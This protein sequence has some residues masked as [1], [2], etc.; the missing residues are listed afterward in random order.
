LRIKALVVLATAMLLFGIGYLFY[1]NMLVALVCSGFSYYAIPAYRTYMRERRDRM[2]SEQFRYVLY[3]LSSLL[4]AGRSVE[5][6]FRL[7]ENDLLTL[8]STSSLVVIPELVRVNGKVSNGETIEKALYE[9]GQRTNQTDIK[10]FAEVFSICK[11]SGGDLIE[12]VRKTVN[13]IAEKME[14]EQEIKII[15]A[16]KKFEAKAMAIVPIAIVALLAFSS[17]EY[18]DPLYVGVGRVIMTFA[19]V[20]FLLCYLW[21]TKIT[22]IRL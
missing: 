13:M 14:V 17:P 1:K 21:I 2:M 19:I 9:F 20:V 3:S 15:T 22:S 8:Y 6:A 5:N 10:N 12:V 7:V 4:A 11:R 18:M 16:Q